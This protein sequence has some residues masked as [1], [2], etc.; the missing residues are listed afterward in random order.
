MKQIAPKLMAAIVLLATACRKDTPVATQEEISVQSPDVATGNGFYLL[1]EGDMGLNKASLDRF[2]YNTGVYY[3]N[4]YPQINPT[5]TKELG[6]VGNDIQVYGGK[7][8]AV[9]NLSDKVEVMDV[10]TAKRVGVIAIQNCRYITFYNGKAYVSSYAST[11]GNANAGAGFVAEIDTATLQITRQVNVGRQPEEMAVVNGKLYVANSGGYT[12]A[13]YDRTVSVV[14]LASFTETKRIDVAINLHRLKAD[15]HGDIYVTSRGSYYGVSSRLFVVNTQTDAVKDSFALGASNLCIQ[16]DSAYV[17]STEWNANTNSN[18]ISYALVNVQTET[19]I[20]KSFITD[21][22]AA[23]I[24][25]PYGIAVNPVNRDIFVTD[26]KDYVSS[27]T[28]YCFDKTGKKKWSVTAGDI[29]A[30][31]AFITK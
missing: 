1:N 29:P 9:I 14:D 3:R 16:G 24:K 21:G 6:D 23:S 10:T 26:A 5:A 11:A 20:S 13:N 15:R 27:G 18:T 25:V 8:Y 22:T 2:N 4:I 28:L 17:L 7:L 31:I 12:P 19:I 30:H